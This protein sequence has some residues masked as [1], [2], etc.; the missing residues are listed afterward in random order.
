MGSKADA[1]R[2]AGL[3]EAEAWSGHETT[4]TGLNGLQLS[5]NSNGCATNGLKVCFEP[6]R[7]QMPLH[8]TIKSLS[9]SRSDQ[10][11]VVPYRFGYSHV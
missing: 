2:P 5:S 9:G 3:L 7:L 4:G 10:A 1:V 11:S 8:Q 6:T